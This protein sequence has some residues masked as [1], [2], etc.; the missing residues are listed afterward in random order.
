MEIHIPADFTLAELQAFIEGEKT[1]A[2]KGYYTAAE[3]AEHFGIHVRKM[4][5]ILKQAK[6]LKR[7]HM[8]RVRR[9]ALDDKMCSVPA[10]A[11]IKKDDET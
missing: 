10:Y 9:L 7:L 6:K 8:I 2:V 1:E 4:H 5:E 11:L 3:W